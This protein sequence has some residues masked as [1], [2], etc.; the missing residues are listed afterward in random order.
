MLPLYR[1][2]IHDYSRDERD[3]I[4]VLWYKTKYREWL[5]SKNLVGLYNGRERAVIVCV[6]V[7][8]TS[9]PIAIILIAVFV[10]Q[11]LFMTGKSF[12][13]SSKL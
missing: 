2:F 5:E 8:L 1:Y 4:E 9:Y 10:E 12:M 11:L 3:P 6:I 13:Q 7:P